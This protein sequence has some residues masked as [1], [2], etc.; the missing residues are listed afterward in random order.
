MAIFGTCVDVLRGGPRGLD[1]PC[2]LEVSEGRLTAVWR[3]AEAVERRKGL[4][5]VRELEE[6]EVLIPGL[7]DCH[8]HLPQFC[9]MGAGI[10][11]P[12]MGPE[13]FLTHYAFPTEAAMADLETARSTYRQA[14]QCLLRH[15]T[16]CAVIFGSI[17]AASCKVREAFS[18][19]SLLFWKAFGCFCR[20]WWT[21][22]WSSRALAPW[23]A[24]SAWTGT[25]PTTTWRAPR[26]L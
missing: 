18:L 16:T 2:L 4:A 9:Y 10:D 15:G 5:T 26:A 22:P 11:K 13:G 23:W 19:C 20:S 25:A 21:W 8:V 6:D 24:R 12:L 14:L 1:G 7:I 3:G 17:H